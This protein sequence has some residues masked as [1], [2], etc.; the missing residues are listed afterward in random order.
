MDL[1]KKY[2]GRKNISEYFH[3]HLEINAIVSE[4]PINKKQAQ[5]IIEE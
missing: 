1:S 3:F 4:S 5:I 2:Q